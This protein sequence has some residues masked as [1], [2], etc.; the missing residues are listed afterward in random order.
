[1]PNLTLYPNPQIFN[2]PNSLYNPFIVIHQLP[3][4]PTET[5][6]ILIIRPNCAFN[7]VPDKYIFTEEINV[8]IYYL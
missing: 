6:Y 4:V 8:S 2:H 5:E 7:I 1:M 3:H